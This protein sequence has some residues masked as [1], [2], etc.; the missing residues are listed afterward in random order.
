MNGVRS[1][2]VSAGSNQ[3]GASDTCTAHGICP[4]GALAAGDTATRAVIIRARP[5]AEGIRLMSSPHVLVACAPDARHDEVGRDRLGGEAHAELVGDD[6][7]ERG[8][9]AL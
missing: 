5:T 4:S 3:V 2:G 7:R 9:R 6:L 8:V 1:A